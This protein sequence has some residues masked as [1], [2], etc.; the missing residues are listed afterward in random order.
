MLKGPGKKVYLHTFDIVD[1]AFSYERELNVCSFLQD[2]SKGKGS[3]LCG[4]HMIQQCKPI[5]EFTGRMVCYCNMPVHTDIA[6]C[7][8]NIVRWH[9]RVHDHVVSSPCNHNVVTLH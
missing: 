1:T 5:H 8:P 3:S 4:V 9:P 7:K 6:L 2:F